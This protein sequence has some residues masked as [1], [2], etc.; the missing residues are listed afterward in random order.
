MFE[1]LKELNKLKIKNVITIKKE[2]F[3]ITMDV[4]YILFKYQIEMDD[5]CIIKDI[6]LN[7]EIKKYTGHTKYFD[8][9]ENRNGIARKFI[10][11]YFNTSSAY[12]TI[13]IN[14]DIF[15]K[16]CDIPGSIFFI[17]IEL[18]K[19]DYPKDALYF[20]IFYKEIIPKCI[21]DIIFT[22]E[23]IEEIIL[24]NI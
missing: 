12:V 15:L 6:I 21:D 13:S 17:K 11:K 18:E 5:K 1:N 4:H 3:E 19:L 16:N 22:D 10:D 23:E 9:R 7:K 14:R 8:N 20:Y 24:L 2:N